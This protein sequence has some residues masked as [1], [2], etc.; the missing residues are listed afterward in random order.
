MVLCAVLTFNSHDTREFNVSSEQTPKMCCSTGFLRITLQWENMQLYSPRLSYFFR[1][2]KQCRLYVSVVSCCLNV[3]PLIY[4]IFVRDKRY[5]H[6][7]GP[8]ELSWG[9]TLS[10][11]LPFNITASSPVD[12]LPLPGTGRLNPPISSIP[13]FSVLGLQ[14]SPRIKDTFSFQTSR[15]LT[16]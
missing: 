4:P 2:T 14:S 10:L 5:R 15:K 7:Q 11:G 9:P 13:P 8:Q 12:G 1:T 3:T 6:L 16:R